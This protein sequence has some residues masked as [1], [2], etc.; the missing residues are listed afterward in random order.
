MSHGF[1]GGRRRRK[2]SG[3]RFSQATTRRTIQLYDQ[4][5]REWSASV[6]HKSGM[7]TGLITPCFEAPWMP[8]QRYLVVN[9]D[10]AT[11]LYINYRL[12]YQ[13]RRAALEEF[14]GDAVRK[15][16]ANK[17]EAPVKG[18]YSE[19]ILDTMGRPPKALEPVVAAWQGNPWIL[20][21]DKTPDPR[22]AA[23]IEPRRREVTPEDIDG[24]D[25]GPAQYFAQKAGAPRAER[26]QTIPDEGYDF[27]TVRGA[28]AS[29]EEQRL[30]KLAAEGDLDA[31]DALDRLSGVTP[32]PPLAAD[33][34]A[35]VDM[36]TEGAG[37]EVDALL[38]DIDDETSAHQVDDDASD[39]E[40]DELARR[41]DPDAL[42]GRTVAP[43]A[44]DRAA[45]QA[46]RRPTQTAVPR[47]RGQA[48][49]GAREAAPG[50][51]PPLAPARRSGQK[52]KRWNAD[53]PTLADG[54]AP[55]VAG[56]ND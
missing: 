42:G 1:T 12:M 32:A 51:E 37:A 39:D 41:A 16:A 7:P 2:K 36:G 26:K 48:R 9:P 3:Q 30:L 25:F 6:E 45:R 17:W 38:E 27:S 54:A 34:A 53:R 31:L 28:D 56:R 35:S 43:Q 29:R 21:F 55:A 19:A 40:T 23:F 20:G 24:Y 22:L 33:E 8:D 5:G 46:P 18:A 11:E 13:H 50:Q 14:H 52:P 10:N 47:K 15:A 4:H 44:T 49:G